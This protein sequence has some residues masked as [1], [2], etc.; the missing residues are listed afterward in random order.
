MSLASP[1]R[2]FGCLL[3]RTTWH[4]LD[5]AKACLHSSI[6][7][8]SS[9]SVCILGPFAGHQGIGQNDFAIWSLH[10]FPCSLAVPWRRGTRLSM[11]I[12]LLCRR[13]AADDTL[14]NG[15]PAVGPHFVLGEHALS[16]VGF[17][18]I[19]KSMIAGARDRGCKPPPVLTGTHRT[20][21]FRTIPAGLKVGEQWVT[22]VRLWAAAPPR[23]TYRTSEAASPLQGLALLVE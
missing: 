22:C 3:Q 18:A 17:N 4:R 5:T 20:L 21:S 19:A 11:R 13:P 8:R 2:K 1:C 14:V 16:R 23:P 12:S 15:E 9:G 7:P 6:S 10:D